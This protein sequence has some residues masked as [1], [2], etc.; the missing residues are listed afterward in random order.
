MSAA[1]IIA[2]LESELASVGPNTK[3]FLM[4]L[5][6]RVSSMEAA[7][8]NL[9]TSAAAA[10][11]DATTDVENALSAGATIAAAAV[12]PATL[13]VAIGQ[14]AVPVT[15]LFGSAFDLAKGFVEGLEGKPAA[16]GASQAEVD[17]DAAGTGVKNLF[18]AFDET[19][20]EP[21]FGKTP[22]ATS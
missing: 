12:N 19:L 5:T 10:L 7:F 8:A 3:A 16:A 13:A 11:G 9:G 18:D 15:T 6:A 21:L 14:V 17:G 22:P 2:D 1:T 20:I 4:A